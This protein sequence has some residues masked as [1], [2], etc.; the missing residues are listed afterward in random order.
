[1]LEGLEKHGDLLPETLEL[2][3][4]RMTVGA[5]KS[6]L[7][8]HIK[9]MVSQQEAIDAAGAELEQ[10]IEA[11]TAGLRSMRA[12]LGEEIMAQLGFGDRGGGAKTV[13]RKVRGAQKKRR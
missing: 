11:R 13:A 1:M 12:K 9:T 7:E 8:G 6:A 2:G 10:A 5:I 4:E 3:G